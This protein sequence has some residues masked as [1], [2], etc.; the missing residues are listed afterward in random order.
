MF[1]VAGSCY[2]VALGVIHLLTPRLAPVNP[3]R[4][5]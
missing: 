3:D 5:A 1:L 2:L 4:L